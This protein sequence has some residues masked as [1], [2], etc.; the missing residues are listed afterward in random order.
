MFRRLT[1]FNDPLHKTAGRAKNRKPSN[2]TSSQTSEKTLIKLYTCF[3][4]NRSCQRI[5]SLHKTAVRAISRKKHLKITSSLKPHWSNF[6]GVLL[7]LSSTKVATCCQCSK[8]FFNEIFLTTAPS[9][10]KL[11]SRLSFASSHPVCFLY[12]TPINSRKSTFSQRC[13]NRPFSCSWLNSV[14]I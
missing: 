8:Y 3:F 13:T 11:Y 2:D 5:I 14:L 12:S 7:R 10:M 6:V 9:L 4:F 1:S